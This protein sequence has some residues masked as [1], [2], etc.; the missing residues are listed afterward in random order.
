MPHPLSI[1]TG[2]DAAADW[3]AAWTTFELRCQALALSERTLGWYKDRLNAFQ[4]FLREA[5]VAPAPGEVTPMHLRAFLASLR[6]RGARHGTMDGS[7]RSL[8]TLFGYLHS[9][10]YLPSNPGLGIPR[11]RGTKPV[12]P[13]L[14]EDQV[15]ALLDAPDRKAWVGLRDYTLLVLF[16]DTAL[17]LSEALGLTLGDVDL[18]NGML[19]VMGKGRKGRQVPMGRVARR[20]LVRWLQRRGD[21]PGQDLVFCTRTGDRLK[22]R[23][24]QS[25]FHRLSRKAGI[26]GVNVTP[27]ALRHTAATM[28]LRQGGNPLMLQRLLGHSTLAMTNR[29]LQ[30]VGADDLR[31][32]HR[33]ASPMDGLG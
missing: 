31:N 2:P 19:T 27:H 32:A 6:E 9:D 11:P 33:T 28:Y 4:R 26:E 15:R 22:A 12:M 8:R 7:W 21:V 16:L 20:A 17:R 10:G 13:A 30:A 23:H 24:V 5:G 18:A 14:R 29:Y 1:L 25:Q 3:S